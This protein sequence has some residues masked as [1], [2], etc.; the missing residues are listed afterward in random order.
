MIAVIFEVWPREGH[1]DAYLDI[2]AS[3]RDE[4]RQIP[5]FVSIERFDSLTHPGKLLSLSFFE[6]EAALDAATGEPEREA[7]GVVAGPS[8]FFC[9]GL[10]ARAT[11]LATPDDECFVEQTTLVEVTQKRGNGRVNG[12]T[13]GR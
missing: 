7:P 1:R 4:L 5:G 3:L 13:V 11:K 6:D 8:L 2:A 12:L 10:H 9:A